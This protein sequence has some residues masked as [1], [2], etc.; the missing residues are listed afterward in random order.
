MNPNNSMKVIKAGIHSL[1]QDTGRTGWHS[2]GITSGGPL[3]QGA[4]YWANLLCNNPKECTALEITLGGLVLES[5]V[6]T[7]IA[8]TGADIPLS[9]NNRPAEL[10]QSHSINPGDRIE[11]GFARSGVRAYLAVAEA[12]RCNL[13]LTV[14]PPLPGRDWAA[15]RVMAHP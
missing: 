1:L 3:D 8:V 6:K 7:T 14:W 2:M 13:Y 9:I 10:W 5:A 11:L 4:F 12:F 15:C